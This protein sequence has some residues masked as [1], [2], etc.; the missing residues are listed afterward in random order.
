MEGSHSYHEG[1]ADTRDSGSPLPADWEVALRRAGISRG[2]VVD[3]IDSGLLMH[4]GKPFD[5]T[6]I[7]RIVTVLLCLLCT[8]HGRLAIVYPV[9]HFMGLAVLTLEALRARS[10]PRNDPK[11]RPYV[12]CVTRDIASRDDFMGFNNPRAVL[13]K[14]FYPIGMLRL[15][16]T[17]RDFSRVRI[18]RRSVKP[19]LIFSTSLLAR[20]PKR[21]ARRTFAIV[22]D[23]DEKMEPGEL[24]ALRDWADSHGIPALLYVIT[25]TFSEQAKHLSESGMLTWGWDTETL[26]ALYRDDGIESRF[27]AAGPFSPP[28]D[29]FANLTESKRFV[30]APVEEDTIG[31]QLAEARGRYVQLLRDARRKNDTNLLTGALRLRNT[32][33]ALEEL[34]TPA[35]YYEKEAQ[36]MWGTI[37]VGRRLAMIESICPR[38]ERIEPGAASFLRLTVDLLKSVYAHVADNPSGKPTV[39]LKVIDEAVGRQASMAIVVRN[40]AAKR[41][42]EAFLRHNDMSGSFLL[43]HRIFVVIRQELEHIRRIQTLLFV[44]VPR[45]QQRNMLRYPNARNLAF[46]AY[47]GEQPAIEY[48]LKRELFESDKKH[49]FEQQLDVVSTLS[50]LPRA[51][52]EKL[53]RRPQHMGEV[54][55]EIIYT[56]PQTARVEDIDL[57]PIFENYF[58]EE[59][60]DPEHLEEIEIDMDASR[61]PEE[62]PVDALAIG[63]ES[64]R[65]LLARPRRFVTTYD[66][67]TNMIGNAA[68]RNLKRNDLVILINDSVLGNLIDLSIERVH[69]HPAMIEV[70]ALQRSWIEALRKGMEEN[71]DTSQSLLSKMQQ[72]GSSIRTPVAIYLWHRGAVIGPRDKTDIVRLGRIYSNDFLVDGVNRIFA[73]VERL[74]RIHRSLARR[75]RY[76]IPR[77]G[78]SWKRLSDEDLVIDRELNLY[79]EDFADAVRI[80]RVV[81]VE[82]P[83]TV[84]ASKLNYTYEGDAWKH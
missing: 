53:V 23:V 56:I 17:I 21:L 1:R 63:F 40:R 19:Q 31:P 60:L 12:L 34:A 49:S 79:L 9:P 84:D 2:Y 37:P 30:V 52:L 41:A 83:V 15:D 22:V 36:M 6:K 70:I 8:T 10:H 66:E 75:L 68:A 3:W 55:H 48:L 81:G 67:H 29:W 43:E 4:R 80:E 44:A 35:S 71:G 24:I 14:R 65:T 54:V 42:L 47:P 18:R 45:Y 57:Q 77:A 28:E 11:K 38:I 61:E 32:I 51:D 20:L 78:I 46:L 62:G 25:D 76:L 13:H 50:G 74:R 69:R 5:L 58:S 59:L 7:D 26:R 73:A 72:S 16:G 82:S 64:G 39:L 27:E 33:Y